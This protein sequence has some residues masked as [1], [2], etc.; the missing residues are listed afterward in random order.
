MPGQAPNT[1]A[2]NSPPMVQ[3]PTIPMGTTP[4]PGQ[5]FT[6]PPPGHTTPSSGHVTS[7]PTGTAQIF[8]QNPLQQTG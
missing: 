4:T 3:T 5:H 2:P 8:T 1:T 6:P 7:G